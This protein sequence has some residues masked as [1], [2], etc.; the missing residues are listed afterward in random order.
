[1]K[2][3]EQLNASSMAIAARRR[4]AVIDALSGL[5]LSFDSRVG[6][7]VILF[8]VTC[9]CRTGQTNGT[10]YSE[11]EKKRNW[12]ESLFS[13]FFEC[14]RIVVVVVAGFPPI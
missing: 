13:I 1:M 12:K 14:S 3:M 9:A 2:I 11:K 7:N 5:F 4:L 10:T 6:K 8:E